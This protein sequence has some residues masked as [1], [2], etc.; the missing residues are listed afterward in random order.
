MEQIFRAGAV[1][2]PRTRRTPK[3]LHAFFVTFASVFALI[4]F[5]GFSRTFFIPVVEG[6]FSRPWVVHVHGALFFTWTGLLLLQAVLAATRRLKLHRRIGAI[7]AWLIVPM[8]VLGS[9][10]AV[11]DTINDFH[12]GEGN[13]ALS[14]FYGE[15]A[16]LAMFGLLAGAA[17]LLRNKPE[18]HKR[19]VIL[20]SLGLLGAAFG[21]I[22]E[23]A[24]AYPY[25]FFGL[26]VSV[27]LY[28]LRSRRSVH[29]ATLIGGAVLL[30]LNFTENLI[31]DS[32]LWLGTA[33]QLLDV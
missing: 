2:T 31:G 26:I 33:H 6:T 16:D 13:G 12:A 23:I 20:G 30:L 9:V 27:A 28:D 29:P 10:V 22:T 21:R 1:R 18:Y 11:R 19:L 15:L 5:T 32:E 7:A 25:V 14:F 3:K 17:M 8:L 4:V 24:P